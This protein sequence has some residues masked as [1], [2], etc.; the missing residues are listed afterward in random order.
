VS[1]RQLCQCRVLLRSKRE[2]SGR[3]AVEDFSVSETFMCTPPFA[4]CQEAYPV[5]GMV[6]C[7]VAAASTLRRCCAG[8]GYLNDSTYQALGSVAAL[9]PRRGRVWCLRPVIRSRHLRKA[10]RQTIVI[11]DVSLEIGRSDRLWSSGS[12]VFR[13]LGYECGICSLRLRRQRCAFQKNLPPNL[14][15][16]LHKWY[17]L[18]S[19][20]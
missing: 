19:P 1:L 10:F 2:S 13:R 11:N 18:P 6:A 9:R 3:R 14:L 17:N 15:R 7:G 20:Q 4:P 12:F 8:V 16:Q 5:Q